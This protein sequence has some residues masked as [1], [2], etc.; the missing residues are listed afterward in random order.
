VDGSASGSLVL[1]GLSRVL[2]AG[3]AAHAAVAPGRLRR[4]SVPEVRG[5][6]ERDRGPQQWPGG[7]GTR[8]ARPSPS[9]QQREQVADVQQQ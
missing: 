3:T 9:P 4:I 6:P 1:V 7:P 5:R 2:G 8:A